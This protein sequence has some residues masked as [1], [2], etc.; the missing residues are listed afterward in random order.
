MV[1]MTTPVALAQGPFFQSPV[2]VLHLIIFVKE[3]S[4]LDITDL[5]FFFELTKMM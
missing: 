4:D 5:K 1:I 3:I 2:S